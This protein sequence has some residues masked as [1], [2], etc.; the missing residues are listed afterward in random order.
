MQLHE[1]IRHL[2]EQQGLTQGELADGYATAS[3]ISII[4]KGKAIPSR[5]VLRKIAEKL[6]KPPYYFEAHVNQNDDALELRTKVE[7]L[8][9]LASAGKFDEAHTVAE[10]LR[11]DI[12]S[13]TDNDLRGRYLMTMGYYSWSAGDLDAAISYYRQALEHFETLKWH[14]RCIDALYGLGNINARRGNMRQAVEYLKEAIAIDDNTRVGNPTTMYRLRI[15]YCNCLMR[16]GRAKEAQRLLSVLAMSTDNYQERILLMLNLTRASQEVGDYQQAY[17]CASEASRLAQERDDLASQALDQEASALVLTEMANYD[18][19]QSTLDQAELIYRRLG[20]NHD[21]DR[22]TIFKARLA[23]RSGELERVDQLL[24]SL[25]RDTD[26]VIFAQAAQL[27]AE[28]QRQL[29]QHDLAIEYLSSAAEAFMEE[30]RFGQAIDC[31]HQAAG[32]ANTAG[33]APLAANLLFRAINAYNQSRK[34]VTS[35]EEVSS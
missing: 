10:E 9:A 14:H 4:E 3:Y 27:Q 34:E 18:N 12:P 20:K 7:Q 33:N 17:E 23:V 11:A 31:W 6:G 13:T 15:D 30:E 26:K 35:N 16:M 22:V 24:G 28:K 29:G 1:E 5:K 32:I 2:R 8:K 19:A 25:D 21:R